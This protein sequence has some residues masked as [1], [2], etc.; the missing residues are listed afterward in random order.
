MIYQSFARFY[1]DLFDDHLYDRW[2]QYV[3]EHGPQKGHR[4]LDLAGGAGR[5][6]VLLAKEGYD[7]TDLDFSEDMLT[8]AQAHAS[9]AQVKLNLICADMTDLNGLGQYDLVTCFA[10]SLNYLADIDQVTTSMQEVYKHLADGGKFLFDMITPYQTDVVYPGYMYNY[11]DEERGRAIMWSSYQNDDVDH[12]VI[13]DLTFFYQRSDGLY[14]RGGE[15]HLERAYDLSTVVTAV[16]QA[17]FK[18]P[19]VTSD[20][21]QQAV[22][23]QTTRWFFECQKVD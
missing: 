3:D 7:V 13:H 9:D 4:V 22:N 1:D 17:G 11:E 18:D 8:L 23:D 19:K 5:L 2:Q 6:G 14:Q 12:G 10:D 21:G 15:T 20:F 16:K